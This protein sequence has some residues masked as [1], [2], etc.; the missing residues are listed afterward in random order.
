MLAV[1]PAQMVTIREITA[2]AQRVSLTDT[3]L[4]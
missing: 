1:V 3:G 2:V 4:D